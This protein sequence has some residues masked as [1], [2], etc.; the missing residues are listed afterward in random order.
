MSS[1]WEDEFESFAEVLLEV[2]KLI[3]YLF[4]G[5]EGEVLS[6]RTKFAALD[7]ANSIKFYIIDRV[8]IVVVVISKLGY[9]FVINNHKS[10]HLFII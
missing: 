10:T 6:D 1:L 3:D 9:W 7:I 5:K 4:I 2:F 8:E